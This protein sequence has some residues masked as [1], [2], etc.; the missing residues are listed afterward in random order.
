MKKGQEEIVGFIMI[1]VLVSIIF[2][3]FLGI[4]LRDKGPVRAE[5]LEAYQYLESLSEFTSD[6][7][8]RF[9]PDYSRIGE[10]FSDCLDGNKCIDGRDSCEALNE[11]VKSILDSSLLVN[12]EA[13][14]KGYI[15]NA[16]YVK[17]N[18]SLGSE[19]S[20]IISL[21]KGNCSSDIRG[22]EYIMPAFPGRI[23]IGL[24]MCS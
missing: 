6:C 4:G 17:G 13:S 14:M 2:L 21:S 22:A 18:S 3:I 15:L 20:N 8:I 5:S 1:I 24:E 19:S 23:I 16:D 7:A 12:N 10:L 9:V 11:T